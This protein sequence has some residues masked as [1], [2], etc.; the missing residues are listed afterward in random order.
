MCVYAANTNFCILTKQNFLK[1]GALGYAPAGLFC[2]RRVRGHPMGAG[3]AHDAATHTP[4]G[5]AKLWA[6][7]F[8]QR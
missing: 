5:K 7:G 3:H 8:V 1:L 4:H 2:L 6:S